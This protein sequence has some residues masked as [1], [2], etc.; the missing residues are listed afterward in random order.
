MTDFKYE[1]IEETKK[2][3]E[4]SSLF[5]SQVS[6]LT[7]K[8]ENK[9]KPN[10]T[11]LRMGLRQ[12]VSNLLPKS[13]EN[14]LEISDLSNSYTNNCDLR[15]VM[16]SH[17]ELKKTEEG[18]KQKEEPHCTTCKC[19]ESHQE[20]LRYLSMFSYDNSVNLTKQRQIENSYVSPLFK[21]NTKLSQIFK[22]RINNRTPSKH[23]L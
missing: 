3:L 22:E 12:K 2:E 9:P 13:E 8:S 18:L 14:K 11:Q 15:S 16:T 10:Q 21:N 17:K 6:I 5:A 7:M 19:F 23:S 20:S 4:S 1:E